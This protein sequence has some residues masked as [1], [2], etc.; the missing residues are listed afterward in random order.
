MGCRSIPHRRCCKLFPARLLTEW[1]RAI[2]FTRSPQRMRD[3][4]PRFGMPDPE[5]SLH[6]NGIP[7]PC[8]CV[9]FESRGA[10]FC[11]PRPLD[12]M[13]GLVVS[14]EWHCPGCGWRSVRIE[15]IVIGCCET[16][17]GTFET[18]V[19]FVPDAGSRATAE[20]RH[21]PN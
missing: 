13:S 9:C 4:T 10:A 8:G 15:A 21:L 17:G 5:V 3:P 18:T 6:R 16:F 20:F 19:I 11:L 7:E 14:V 2:R 12:L 1:D